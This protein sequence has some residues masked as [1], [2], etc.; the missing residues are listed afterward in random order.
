M[1]YE[2]EMPRSMRTPITE[3]ARALS[4][5]CDFFIYVDSG[6]GNKI[7][8]PEEYFFKELFGKTFNDPDTDGDKAV[9]KIGQLLDGSYA[10]DGSAPFALF[11]VMGV[12]VDYSVQ[13]MKAEKEGRHDIAWS[14]ALDAHYW[15]GILKA[16]K[17]EKMEPS[18]L[19]VNARRA[20][21]ARLAIDP[22]QAAKQYV[23]SCWQVW[24]E[25]PER[26]KGKA[27]FA[28]EMLK[29]EQCKNLESQAVIEGWCREWEKENIT[30]LAE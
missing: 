22:K 11:Q 6:I 9:Y 10:E 14:F 27:K 26:Y 21:L 15:A 13:A 24:Q 2:P 29:L 12:V 23:Q 28:R 7:A 30:Q 16:S 4:I 1:D 3:A 18:D 5:A 17:A 25:E 19:S 20:A 8:Q